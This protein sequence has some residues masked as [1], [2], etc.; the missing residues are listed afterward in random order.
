MAKLKLK[1][2]KNSMFYISLLSINHIKHL[3]VKAVIYCMDV[4]LQNIGQSFEQCFSV[5]GFLNWP[6]PF[7]K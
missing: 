6:T 3:P 2:F 4:F 1:S 7:R 5:D